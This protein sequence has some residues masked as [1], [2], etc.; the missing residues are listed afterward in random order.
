MGVRGR[1]VLLAVG[2]AV[3]LALVG[4]LGLRGMWN[5]SRL[6]LDDSIRQQAELAAVAFERWV[7]AQRQPLNTLSAMIEAQGSSTTATF[8]ESMRLVVATRPHWIDLQVLGPGGENL[9]T[10]PSGREPLPPALADYLIGETTRR[11]SWTVA[12]DRTLDEARPIFAVAVP[13]SGGGA[14][15]ARVGGSATAELFQNVNLSER[16]VI[17][18]FDSEGRVLFRRQTTET[19]VDTNVSGSPLL[20]VLGDERQRALGD[21]RAAVVE[22][23]SPYDGVRRVYG[24]ARAGLTDCVVIVGIPSEALYEP[25][26]R[27]F[28]RYLYF[29]ILGLLFAVTAALLVARTIVLP[30]R[31]LRGAAQ[32]L[33]GGDLSARAPVG[34][35]REMIELGTAFNQMA[36]QIAERE[37]RLKELD[38]LKSE[39]VSS[40][41]HELRTP[42]TTI[43]TLTRLLQRGGQTEE[44]QREYLETIAAEC[45]RQID[46]VLN[47]LDL[48]R[49]E[50]GA[51]KVTLA[52]VNV[53]EV[54][55]ACA[56][57][58]QHAAEARGLGLL[59]DPPA[60]GL[61]DLLTDGGALRRVLCS[62]I[63]NA[64]KYTPEGGR[65]ILSAKHAD[66]SEVAITVADTGCGIL[67]EDAPHVFEKFYRGRPAAVPHGESPGETIDYNEASGVGLGLYLA[68]SIV[69]Q[70]GGRISV[71]NTA[72]RG[73]VFTVYLPAWR[74]VEGRGASRP[75]EEKQNAEAFARG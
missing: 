26:R 17:G 29:G 5:A 66:E 41:S 53:E 7:D 61:P 71:E 42:L 59:I 63:E 57:V 20:N 46:L 65:I 68:H 62:L 28:T 52:R 36:G 13:V 33:G 74:G 32:S 64:I 4:A 6:Q 47:L 69:E 38:R 39:F 16:G 54:I 35:G 70:L 45:D 14:V 27:Q 55:S 2:V 12:T 24:I 1:L 50:A 31:R 9:T 15:V 37:E 10:Q 51:F 21:R 19:P 58:E 60:E 8:A 34:G 11:G 3:P 75:E 48:S 56:R 44:E 18:V 30:V 49:I 67:P 23:E 72:P 43:K 40:V 73:T 25:A 22:V